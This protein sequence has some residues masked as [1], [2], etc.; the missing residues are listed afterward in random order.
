MSKKG[1]PWDKV[2]E[3]G[4]LAE[5][6][7]GMALE[8]VARRHERTPKAILWRLGTVFQKRLRSKPV[9]SL[10]QLCEE[11]HQGEDDMREILM[12]LSEQQLHPKETTKGVGGEEGMAMME[13]INQR[14][15]KIL[16]IVKK[17]QED[18]L[19]KKKRPAAS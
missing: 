16:R 8:A 10:D 12:Q 3:E 6:R 13:E 17:I 14:T 9:L 1:Q 7:S 19:L 18:L 2:E 11:F 4:M 5:L 15:L